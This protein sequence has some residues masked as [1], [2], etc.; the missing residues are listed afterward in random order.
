M[1][2]NSLKYAVFLPVV[3]ALFWLCPARFRVPILLAAS[4]IFY[5]AWRPVYLLLILLLTILNY[6]CALRIAKSEKHKKAWLI[7]GIL[8]NLGTLAYFKYF[9]FLEDV[10]SL[11]T[12]PWGGDFHKVAI[13]IILPLGISF[14]V[15][16]FIHYIV[17]VY[18]GSKP[19]TNFLSFALFPSFFPTQIAGPIKR[20]E[21]FVPQ[22]TQDYKL[23]IADFDEG[24]FLILVGLFKKMLLA[25]NLALFVNGGFSNVQLFSSFDMWLFAIAFSFQVYLDF[26]GYADIARGSA[27]LFGY[28]VPVNFDFPYVAGSTTEFWNRWHMTLGSWLRDYLYIPLG[29]SRAGRFNTSR[30][31]VITMVLGGLWHGAEFHYLLWGLYQGVCLSINREFKAMR[32]DWIGF[33]K[34]LDSAAGKRVSVFFTFFVTVIGMAIFR[35][36]D[37][38]AVVAVLQ[39]MLFIDT[40]SGAASNLL[41]VNYPLVYP[42]SFL[43]IPILVLGHY[44]CFK[45][46]NH[47][48]EHPQPLFLRAAYGAVLIFTIV[49]LAADNAPRFIYYQ[50]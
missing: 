20:Y 14:F 44:V 41:A 43:L 38:G 49:A 34:F 25:D 42:A 2:F 48:I 15:F 39:K 35:A 3:F 12:K 33:S 32:T 26:G 22:L 24:I 5:M 4:Y 27:K 30:N 13:E 1:N 28:R 11:L 6:F 40:T 17:D 46:R 18:R 16:E 19:V 47:V 45:I 8:G 29:G 50:F 9:Y 7:V 31:L 36:Q 23:T 37:S 10:V 21:D